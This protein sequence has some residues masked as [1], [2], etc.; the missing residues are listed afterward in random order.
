MSIGGGQKG[1]MGMSFQ[2]SF[3]SG[4]KVTYSGKALHGNTLKN[5]EVRPSTPMKPKLG[6]EV[7]QQLYKEALIGQTRILVINTG[8][9]GTMVRTT[10]SQGGTREVSSKNFTDDGCHFV[11]MV[12]EENVPRCCCDMQSQLARMREELY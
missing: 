5:I 8:D 4:N 2:P 12:E 6:I 3:C 10:S 1:A 11:R 7:A 9:V